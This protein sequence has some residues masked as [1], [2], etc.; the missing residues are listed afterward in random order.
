MGCQK[1]IA[2]QIIAQGADYV[3]ALKKIRVIYTR[4]SNFFLKT[5]RKETLTT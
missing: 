5:L 3:L 1:K 2:D 4:M